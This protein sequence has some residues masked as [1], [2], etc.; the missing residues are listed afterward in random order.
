MSLDAV[1][2][3]VDIVINTNVENYFRHFDNSLFSLTD[4]DRLELIYGRPM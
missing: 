3:I 2:A 1:D 4:L